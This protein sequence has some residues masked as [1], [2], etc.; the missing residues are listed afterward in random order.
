[1]IEI[2]PLKQTMSGYKMLEFKHNGKV[3]GGG[4]TLILNDIKPTEYLK[5]MVNENGNIEIWT[6]DEEGK[7]QNINWENRK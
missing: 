3:V 4:D 6:E 1:M 5:I 2:K 7:E